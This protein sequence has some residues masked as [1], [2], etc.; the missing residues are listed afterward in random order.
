MEDLTAGGEK[1]KKKEI[2]KHKVFMY[3]D[4]NYS[5]ISLK[6]ERPREI[7]LIVMI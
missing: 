4:G 5:L 1:R 7:F 6:R 2:K 3:L